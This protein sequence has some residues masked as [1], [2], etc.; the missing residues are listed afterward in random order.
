MNNLLTYSLGLLVC[1]A[2][3]ITDS[4]ALPQKSPD[5]VYLQEEFQPRPFSDTDWSKATKGMEFTIKPAKPEKQQKQQDKAKK[6]PSDEDGWKH[7]VH[8][9]QQVFKILAFGILLSLAAFI[10][11]QLLKK[12]N[13][14]KTPKHQS[15][16]FSDE[17]DRLPSF[18]LHS[19]IREAEARGDFGTAIRLHYLSILQALERTKWIIWKREKTNREY[20]RELKPAPFN[21]DFQQ[22][23]RIFDRVRYGEYFPDEKQYRQDIVPLFTGLL[24]WVEKIAPEKPKTSTSTPEKHA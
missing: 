6:Q 19:H 2:V 24:D 5:D 10:M 1:W 12:T 7:L 4:N 20:T 23:T 15:P 3:S 9:A 11:Y 21:Q 8:L 17:A 18:G 14:T 16:I 22:A 13:N